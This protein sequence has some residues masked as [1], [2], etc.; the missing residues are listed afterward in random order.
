MYLLIFLKSSADVRPD[1]DVFTYWWRYPAN[2]IRTG[3][4]P[5][6]NLLVSFFFFPYDFQH[7]TRSS[8][9]V[10]P[11][12]NTEAHS[13]NGLATALSLNSL[14]AIIQGCIVIEKSNRMENCLIELYKDTVTIT[15]HFSRIGPKHNTNLGQ[16]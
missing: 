12:V 4:L 9:F 13:D 10:I 7:P 3:K 2:L 14:R 8:C 16:L 1:L 15:K 11:K 5:A 6:R